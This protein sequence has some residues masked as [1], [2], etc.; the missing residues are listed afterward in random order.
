MPK[1]TNP[2]GPWTD[3][4]G[5]EYLWNWHICPTTY[6]LYH[7]QDHTWMVYK[8]SHLCQTCILYHEEAKHTNSENIP[9]ALVTPEHLPNGIQI[10]LLIM[11]IQS[12]TLPTGHP[13][14]TF[15]N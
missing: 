8:P 4:Y 9:N 10:S 15:I 2:L 6:H 14:P 3:Q 11:P 13:I 7:H 5:C 1:L 12:T